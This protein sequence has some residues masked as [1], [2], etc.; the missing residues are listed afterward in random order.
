MVKLGIENFQLAPRE[1]GKEPQLDEGSVRFTLRRIP[2]CVNPI[3]LKRAENSPIGKGR[4]IG[5]SVDYPQFSGP[6][7][8]LAERIGSAGG[9]SPAT[10]PEIFYHGL[11][12]GFYRLV[13]NLSQN[14]GATTAAHAVTNFQVISSP[15]HGPKPCSGGKVPATRAAWSA[16]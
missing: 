1:F 13:V 2:N 12:P 9:Y 10:R 7:G 6:N 4:L 16:G 14:N 8:V 3:R 5:T 11:H 15:G